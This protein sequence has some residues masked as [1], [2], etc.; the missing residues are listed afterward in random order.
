MKIYII[1]S[2][3]E[4]LKLA[5][6]KLTGA[7]RRSFQGTMTLKYCKGS[8]R[9]AE[10]VFVMRWNIEVTFEL[11]FVHFYM[12]HNGKN[13]KIRG[14]STRT[15]KPHANVTRFRY[16]IFINFCAIV[17]SASLETSPSINHWQH[18]V[19]RSSNGNSDLENNG[20]RSRNLVL[21]VPSRTQPRQ[22]VRI[23][24]SK[25]FIGVVGVSA[26]HGGIANRHCGR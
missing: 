20:T 10:E 17:F 11:D 6:S 23:A 12:A 22:M 18:F 26:H 3:I 8:A 15:L 2:Q 19:S 25:D 9:L 7:E 1:V 14:Y 21:Q 16:N 4:D 24:R 13:E 5:S